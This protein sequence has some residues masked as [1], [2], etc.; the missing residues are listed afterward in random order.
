MRPKT[1]HI[2]AA[3]VTAFLAL[4]LLSGC[5]K[6]PTYSYDYSISDPYNISS[7]VIEMRVNT[8]AHILVNNSGGEEIRFS[9]DRAVL[10]ANYEDGTKETII[11]RGEG[12]K[13]P[14]DG[15]YEMELAFTGVP[16][17]YVLKDNPP[18]FHPIISY[19]DVNVTTTGEQ[20]FLVVWSPK[21]TSQKDMRIPMKDMPVGEYLK[22]ITESLKLEGT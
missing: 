13:V 22:G 5:V 15:T 3:I 14:S 19:Y 10:T 20:L 21:Q 8:T 4:I 16:V 12:G 6:G 17:K 9:V 18:M 7:G 11:G 2:L 1:I